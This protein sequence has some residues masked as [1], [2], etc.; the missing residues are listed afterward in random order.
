MVRRINRLLENKVYALFGPGRW[1]TNDVKMGVKV[2]YEDINRTRVLAEIAMREAG[3]VPEPS[4]GTHFFNDLVEANIVPLAIDP[5]SPGTVFKEEFFRRRSNVL[6]SLDPG[7]SND[8]IIRVI[9]VP[10]SAEGQYLQVY[11]DS[12]EQRGVGFF[13]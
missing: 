13:R 5:D 10:S 11:L 1:G 3:V 2:S 8:G 12:E 6:T 9:H 7:L 4:F